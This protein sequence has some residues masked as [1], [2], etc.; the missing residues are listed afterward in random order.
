LRISR[1]SSNDTATLVVQGRLGTAGARELLAALGDA[2][3]PGT[4]VLLDLEGVD[5]ISSSGIAALQAAA[6][7]LREAGGELALLRPSEA[8]RLALRLAGSAEDLG[9]VER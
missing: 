5:Y 9:E 2:P 8:V 6:A 1:D 3:A 4:R 7:S